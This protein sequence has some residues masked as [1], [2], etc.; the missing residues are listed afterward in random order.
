[1]T[2]L[3]TGGPV[4]PSV[5]ERRVGRYRR[6]LVLYPR[7]FRAE[8]G[9]DLVQSYHDLLVHCADRRGVGW[10]TARDLITSAARE[11]G[12]SLRGGHWPSIASV[13]GLAALVLVVV[14]VG[15][16]GVLLLPAVV[17]VGLPIYGLTCFAR[18]WTI[19]RAATGGIARPVLAGVASFVPAAGAMAHLGRDAGYFVF[20]AVSASLIVAAAAG[21]VWA[22]YRLGRPVADRPR[23]RLRPLLVL[24]PSVAVLGFIV[25]ASVNS[26][27]NSLGP[28][29]DHSVGN[30]SADTRALW[31]AAHDG[32][33]DE[34]TRLTTETCADPWVKF[35]VGGGRHNAKGMAETQ[36]WS[37]DGAAP[38]GEIADLLG[39]YQDDWYERCGRAD[40]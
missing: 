37:G 32:D 13:L 29:G 23:P 33:L 3:W 15:S 20:L 19:R 16:P 26:Y 28:P 38:F 30:A 39:D 6:L 40:D 2:T 35:P 5:T 1:M 25:G 36:G 31:Q 14:V 17:L 34:A 21:A 12:R 7:A 10:R 9:D 11:R 18:A 24:V 8:F 27:R 4:D 22:A